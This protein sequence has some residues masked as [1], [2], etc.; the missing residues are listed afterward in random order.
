MSAFDILNELKE[1]Y[2]ATFPAHIDEIESLILNIEKKRGDHTENFEAL[3][4][5]AHSLKGSG[6]TYGFNIITSI[7]HQ[8]EDFLSASLIEEDSVTQDK[9]DTVFSYTD[10]LKETHELLENEKTDFKEIS[11]KLELIKKKESDHLLKGLFVGP[12][13]QVYSKM[14]INLFE[15][16]NIQCSTIDNGMT[17]LQRLLHEH[18]DFLITSKENLELNGLALIAAIK[19]NHGK[20]QKI[21]TILITTNATNDAPPGYEPDCIILKNKD[22]SQNLE[23]TMEELRH[24]IL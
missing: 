18:F 16:L 2:L 15:Q 24:S 12:A 21:K 13:S 8:L 6:G 1:A 5:K 4:R 10:L 11:Q 22:F 7:C 9:V 19:L 17:A 14:S 3:Y 23:K 20:N